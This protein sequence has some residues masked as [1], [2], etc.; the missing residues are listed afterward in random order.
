[1]RPAPAA[2]RWRPGQRAL[3]GPLDELQGTRP[4]A[5]LRVGRG[6]LGGLARLLHP[7]VGQV[8]AL[9]A[10]A[11]RGGHHG[12]GQ[13]VH[14]GEAAL[15][16]GRLQRLH[17]LEPGR[18][19]GPKRLGIEGQGLAGALGGPCRHPGVDALVDE[20]LG[21]AI[22]R[23]GFGVAAVVVGLVGEGELML[24]LG[25]QAAG[26]RVGGVAVHAQPGQLVD[27]RGQ[28]L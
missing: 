2:P 5:P 17:Q 4:L 23:D 19:Q 13:V 6:H 10:Q 18:E 21:Q 25:Q 9:L 3:L 12:R 26:L 24:D 8:N 16:G 28:A 20:P 11:G 27:G 15:G 14:G 1:M 22:A 7:L